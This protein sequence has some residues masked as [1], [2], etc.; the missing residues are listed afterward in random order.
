[1]RLEPLSTRER[2]MVVTG[3]A[4]AEAVREQI[5]DLDDRNLVLESSAK[6]ST[7]AIALAAAI[8]VKR[9]PNVIVGSFAADH[10]IGDQGAFESAVREAVE[11]AATGKIVTIG[12]KPTEASVAFGYIKT[13]APLGVSA[14]DKAREVAT[15]TRASETLKSSMRWLRNSTLRAFAFLSTSCQTT[16]QTSTCGFKRP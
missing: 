13:G 15:L 7:A 4:H 14:A 9:E 5:E 6:D 1:E 16:R 8:L 11:V 10:V 2:I 3:K 12:I